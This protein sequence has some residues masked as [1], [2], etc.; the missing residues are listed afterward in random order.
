MSTPTPGPRLLTIGHSN[1][2]AEHFVEL[3]S[4]HRVE[5]LVDVRSWPHSKHAE[6]ADSARLPLLVD[7]VGTDYLYLGHEL[8][9]RPKD[10]DCYDPSGHVLYGKVART[11]SYGAGL[12]KLKQLTRTRT[13]AVMCSEED[14][15]HC[16]RRLLVAKT[17][18]DDGFEIVHIRGHGDLQ[19]ELGI[20]CSPHA[21]LFDD[22]ED[23]WWRSSASVSHR[24]RPRTSSVA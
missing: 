22:D 8:G 17:L 9:G 6:W 12:D 2:R 23:R 20:S 19:P 16:H 4:R 14:P 18:M 15:T 5:L 21:Q 24:Q 13:V 1:H 11:A 3:V 7:T 10:D